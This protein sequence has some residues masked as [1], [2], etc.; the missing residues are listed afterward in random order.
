[1]AD[2]YRGISCAGSGI[3][4]A[5]GISHCIFGFPACIR[6]R[7]GPDPMGTDQA[8]GRRVCLC[9]RPFAD[10]CPDPGYASAGTA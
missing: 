7:Y 2:P 1:M 3:C 8:A 6:H 4:S 9:G 5:L 10:L